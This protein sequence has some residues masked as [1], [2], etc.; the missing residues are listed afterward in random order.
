[1]NSRGGINYWNELDGSYLLGKVFSIPVLI[2]TID[3]QDV[4]IKRD[5]ASVIVYFDLI[6]QLPDRP[7][8]KWGAFNKC[9][10]GINC[11]DSTY[12]NIVGLATKMVLSVHIEE[13][14]GMNVVSMFGDNFQLSLKCKYIQFLGPTVYTDA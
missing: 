10:C 13:I 7:P 1:M 14:D 11:G 3:L 8:S 6:D 12:L 9:R 4:L 5:G 2:S